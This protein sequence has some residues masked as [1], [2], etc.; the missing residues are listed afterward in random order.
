MVSAVH[1]KERSK[2]Y[3]IIFLSIR[4]L[5]THD[6]THEIT[7]HFQIF[8]KIDTFLPLTAKK[9]GYIFEE[10]HNLHIIVG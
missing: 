1:E 6:I 8:D 5:G 10:S 4:I 3:I 7:R 2:K 9:L